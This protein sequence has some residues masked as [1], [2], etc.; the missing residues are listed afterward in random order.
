MLDIFARKVCESGM[1]TEYCMRCEI[2]IVYAKN[3]Q[4]DVHAYVWLS[5]QVSC[6]K[7]YVL[8]TYV[9]SMMFFRLVLVNSL[10]TKMQENMVML[11]DVTIVALKEK[12]KRLSI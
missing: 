7:K 3:R 10:N 9:Y 12:K 6:L 2:L 11:H 1:V 8:S 4:V 5:S